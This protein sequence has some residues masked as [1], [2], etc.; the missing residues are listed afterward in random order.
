MPR[1]RPC[2][3][4][5]GAFVNADIWTMRTP[6]DRATALAWQDGHILAV[7]S[8]RDIEAVA[9]QHGLPVTDV[10][11]ARVLPGFVDAHMHFLHLGIHPFRPFLQ[12]ATS[13][14]DALAR[15]KAWLEAHPGRDAVIA[16]AWDESRWPER[17]FPLRR[18]L[19]A[20]TDRPLVLRRIDGHTAVAN[21]AALALIRAR[22]PGPPEVDVDSGLLLEDP[23]LYLNDVIPMPESQ[24][25]ASLRHATQL[26]HQEGVTTV[27]AYERAPFRATV[28]EAARRGTLAVRLVLS[29][30]PQQLA[31]EIA[32]GFRTG[33]R[34]D[35]AGL[36][37]DGGLKLFLDGSIGGR[38]AHLREPYGGSHSCGT[39]TFSDDEL[40]ELSQRAHAAGIQ[41][42]M[43]AI[44]DAAID[45]GLAAL[46]ALSRRSDWKNNA[47]RHRFEHYELAHDEQVAQTGA[48]GIVVSAQPNF[49]G[50]WSAKGGLY[51]QAL[52]DRYRINNRFVAFKKQGIRLAF[53]SDGMPFGPRI[54]I[55]A[56]VQHPEP[57]QRLSVAEAVWHYT[58]G[59]A[60]ACHLES[61]VGSLE[62]GKRADFTLWR[63]PALDIKK[64]Q[65]QQCILTGKPT[66]GPHGTL[67]A[68]ALGQQE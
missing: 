12:D 25:E 50:A 4:V 60:Y 18:E 46:E 31:D 22:W 59:A 21:R 37:H 29:I 42:H 5:N 53:G 7:G 36:L 27:A 1:G 67:S 47:L 63:G 19:D 54:G 11:G 13:L 68:Y 23:S 15:V 14:A 65:L 48:L 57:D 2:P 43:H 62:V 45:Q 38:T 3:H 20:L 24:L 51:H 39:R 66:S 8:N 26:A 10:D 35:E 52:G 16:E 40:R 49:V 61:Q 56:A 32:A 55:T 6:D 34:H 64:W 30:Y 28:L 44:G 41:L 9:R 17:R 33:R 58:L